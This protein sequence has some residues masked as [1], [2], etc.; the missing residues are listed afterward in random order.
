MSESTPTNSTTTAKSAS[1]VELPGGSRYALELHVLVSEVRGIYQTIRWLSDPQSGQH[2]T[3]AERDMLL[4][5]YHAVWR[6]D[7]QVTR[8][9]DV[10]RARPVSSPKS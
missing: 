10:W 5:V 1:R 2:L 9:E 8:L 4:D 6:L 7:L 3:A